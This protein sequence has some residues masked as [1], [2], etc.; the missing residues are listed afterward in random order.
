MIDINRLHRVLSTPTPLA[1]DISKL[2]QIGTATSTAAN[3]PR[4]PDLSVSGVDTVSVL[5]TGA[6]QACGADQSTTFTVHIE[7][8][9][10]GRNA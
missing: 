1:I 9:G 6:V 5:P 8:E 2:R 4:L 7:N 3:G 10:P